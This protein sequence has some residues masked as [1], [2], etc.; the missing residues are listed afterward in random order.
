[1]SS[2]IPS[3]RPAALRLLP[4]CLAAL[5]LAWLMWE[6]RWLCD[7]AFI[8][9]RYSK[10]LA[11]GLGL[12]YNPADPEIEGY[13]NFL[14]VV[15]LAGLKWIGAGIPSAAIHFSPARYTTQRKFE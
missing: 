15:Y 6:F 2:A 7:D 13:S 3:P 10:N 5:P 12:R 8:S 11:D 1:M 14:W 4:W 9:F